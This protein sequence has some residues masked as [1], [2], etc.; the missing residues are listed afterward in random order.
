[1][2]QALRFPQTIGLLLA[3]AGSAAMAQP[4]GCLISP[5]RT[6]DVGSPVIGVLQSIEVERGDVVKRGQVL[7]TL[8]ADVE[9]AQVGLASSR[10]QAQ[11]ELQSAQKANE[12]AQKKRERTEDLFRQDFISRQ[13]VDQAVAD[14][15][16]AEG[17]LNQTREQMRHSERELGL[18][19]AQLAMRVIR[20]PIDGVVIERHLDVGERVDER[21]ILK[22]ATVSPL[23]VEVVLPA[24]LYG[25]VQ[26]GTSATV[27]PDL[28]SLPGAQAQ[29]SIVDR[30]ID[31][32]SNTFRARLDLPNE[33]GRMPAG[34]RCKVEFAGLAMP[35]ATGTR[36]AA[37]PAQPALAPALQPPAK[38]A[39]LQAAPAAT[40]VAPKLALITATELREGVPA[41][42]AAPVRS[43]AAGAR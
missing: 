10:A 8:R 29:V 7:A 11:A 12:F 37:A 41:T 20:S 36:P 25:Q 16:V 39:A 43:A 34:T 22:V 24:S 21:A 15:Q 9:R 4:L 28:P 14:A 35:A 32:A 30:I 23:K 31:P 40:T 42:A 2:K 33:D 19:S 38:P 1:M 27:T 13:A 18:A 3:V 17:H 6:A 5:S 26:T